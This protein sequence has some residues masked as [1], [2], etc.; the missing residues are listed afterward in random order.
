MYHT[1]Y[2]VSDTFLSNKPELWFWW[3]EV[4]LA[5]LQSVLN[6]VRISNN[7]CE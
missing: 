7:L 3:V 4:N 1:S 6:N 5:L 2:L